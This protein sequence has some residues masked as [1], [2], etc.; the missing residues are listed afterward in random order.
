[1]DATLKSGVNT[2]A[3]AFKKYEKFLETFG[4]EEF[5]LVALKRPESVDESEAL[6]SLELISAALEKVPA[7]LEVVGPTNLKAFQERDGLMGMFPV[8]VEENGKKRLPAR[9]VME[10]LRNGVPFLNMLV[11]QDGLSMGIVAR[12]SQETGLDPE[13]VDRVQ[14]DIDRV[15]SA[16]IPKGVEFR[17]VGPPLVRKALHHYNKQTAFRFG[18]LCLIISTAVSY[19]IFKSF[20]AMIITAVVVGLCDFWIL[21]IMALLGVQINSV[22]ALAFGL[23]LISSVEPVIHFVTHFNDR[24]HATGDRVVAAKQTLL[25]GAG[26]CLTTSFTTAFGFSSLLVASIPMVR[27]LGLILSLGPLLAFILAV[28]LTPAFLTVM[29]P[30]ESRAY[31]S[32]STDFLS[33]GYTRVKDFVFSHPRH[34]LSAVL[35]VI[36]V[37]LTGVPRIRSDT[38]IMRFLNESTPEAQDIRFVEQNLG[39]VSFLDVVLEGEPGT[40]SEAGSWGTVRQVERRIRLIPGVIETDS[41]LRLLELLH[42][43]VTRKSGA[44]TPVFEDHPESIP[45]LLMLISSTSE[46]RRLLERHIDV[47]ASKLRITVRFVNSPSRTISE[48]I[49]MVRAA[50]EE[51]TGG[52]LKTDIT[53]ELAMFEGQAAELVD[54]Q[55]YSLL[56]AVVY[57]SALLAVQFRSLALGLASLLPQVLPQTVIFGLMGWLGISL[58][59]VTVFAASVSIGL[60]VDNTVHYLSQLRRELLSGGPDSMIESALTAAYAVTGRAMISNHAV[61]FFG[62]AALLLSPYRPVVCFGI[63]GS[64]AILFSLVGDLVF[65]P[66]A[67]LSSS[68]FRKLLRREFLRSGHEDTA[69]PVQS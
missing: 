68:L 30:L 12:I 14:R 16:N 38:Q 69:S 20:G 4:Q 37:M 13:A 48:T 47:T 18:L 46:G 7:V 44:E 21:A 23:V 8:Y 54:S 27:Q 26:P 34:C 1:V 2:E 31:D 41:P 64:A 62:F 35:F 61:I 25:I 36:A 42:K 24:L 5:I 59:T 22:T 67:I 19:Y 66:S 29:R 43:T 32:I 65:M 58:D 55:T 45:E 17:L 63:L 11:S 53:G 33:R 10:E 56:L 28:V 9:E 52:S 50:A 3:E 57:M 51:G 15:V 6:K 40:F 39:S 49:G 60:T